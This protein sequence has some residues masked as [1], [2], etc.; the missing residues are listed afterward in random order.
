MMDVAVPANMKV[1][2][3]QEEIARRGW[4]VTAPQ[5]L[6]AGRQAR[7]RAD[8]SARDAPS[9]SA[10]ASSRARCT[11][12]IR[13]CRRTSRRA[14]CCTSWPDRPASGC[15]STAPSASARRWRCRPRRTPGLTSACHIQGGID[16]WK[17]ASGPLRALTALQLM[18]RASSTGPARSP[19]GLLGHWPTMDAERQLDLSP[20]NDYNHISVWL[21]ASSRDARQP[22]MRRPS[23]RPQRWSA[24]RRRTLRPGPARRRSRRCD[25]RR[26]AIRDFASRSWGLQ[27]VLPMCD[28]GKSDGGQLV[29]SHRRTALPAPD[30]RTGRARAVNPRSSVQ[31]LA[32]EQLGPLVLRVGEERLRARSSR[33][34]GRRP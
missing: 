17:K 13:A 28:T 27:T 29:R 20:C 11:C 24:G 8:R 10:T 4:A 12:P 30:D 15:C 5:A 7:R 32:Q 6:G 33:R 19:A 26:Q 9:A 1:G 31:N 3:H 14:A 2:L 18:T 16:A 34:S 25:R 21:K 23:Y 22:R